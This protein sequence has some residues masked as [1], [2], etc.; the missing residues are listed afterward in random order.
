[1]NQMN[2]KKVG[3][4]L[5]KIT[6]N[7]SA[8]RS[9]IEKPCVMD[10]HG[11]KIFIH[12]QVM[13]TMKDGMKIEKCVWSEADM[14]LTD[15]SIDKKMFD[16]SGHDS[17]TKYLESKGFYLENVQTEQ[18]TRWHYCGRI[19]NEKVYRIQYYREDEDDE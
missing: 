7:V 2:Y 14:L 8:S 13:L 12:Q 16:E 17:F 5:E 3:N 10:D 15:I 9:L 18:G 1:M 6:E 11:D 19:P 4:P